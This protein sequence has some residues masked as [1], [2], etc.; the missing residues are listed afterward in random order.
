[1]KNN[2]PI[3]GAIQEDVSIRKGRHHYDPFKDVI[4]ITFHGSSCKYIQVVDMVAARE[5]SNQLRKIL[6]PNYQEL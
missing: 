1:M 5:L 4:E 6:P 3:S 2:E